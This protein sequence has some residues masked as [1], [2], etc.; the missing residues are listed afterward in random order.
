[1]R[2]VM[3]TSLPGPARVRALEPGISLPFR[4]AGIDVA[5]AGDAERSGML[6]SEAPAREIGWS[7]AFI[8]THPAT[9]GSGLG[10]QH[11]ASRM[12]STFAL[13]HID[14]DARL[15]IHQ[16]VERIRV[17]LP[18]F[19]NV[20]LV[21]TASQTGVRRTRRLAGT[22]RLTAAEVSQFD[23]R[24]EDAIGRGNDY[25]R[26]GP[27]YDIPYGCLVPKSLDGLLACGRCVSSDDEALASCARSRSA[28]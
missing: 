9:A 8:S 22:F 13:S 14:T 16:A 3:A 2:R 28:G 12:A 11:T 1:M 18:G 10:Q 24:H 26:Q 7:S 21:E 6:T 23:Y 17:E 4:L 19:E 5:L 25:R 20:W 27:V 15:K